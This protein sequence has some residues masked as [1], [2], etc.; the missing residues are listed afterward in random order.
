MLALLLVAAVGAS[1]GDSKQATSIKTVTTG[2]SPNPGPPRFLA[3]LEPAAKVSVV[4][5]VVVAHYPRPQTSDAY[6]VSTVYIWLR[7]SRA[8]ANAMLKTALAAQAR[9]E[10]ALGRHLPRLV[11]TSGSAF[12]QWS[13]TPLPREAAS[14]AHCLP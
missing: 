2:P 10:Q 5:G 4:H 14:L 6:I 11:G 8:A 1:C 9:F 13:G 7:P 12:F 3:C